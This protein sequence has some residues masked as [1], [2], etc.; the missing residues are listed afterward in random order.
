M[1]F[2]FTNVPAKNQNN[3]NAR[4][5]NNTNQAQYTRIVSR[6]QNKINRMRNGECTIRIAQLT[7]EDKTNLQTGLTNLGYNC[8]IDGNRMHIN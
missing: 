4:P 3:E 5:N 6:I 2:D 8:V 1:S 7:E